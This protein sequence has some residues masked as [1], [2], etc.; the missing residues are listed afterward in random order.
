LKEASTFP[1]LR[2]DIDFKDGFL[3]RLPHVGKH[4]HAA[5]LLSVEA[6]LAATTDDGARA[7]EALIALFQN[8][9]HLADEPLLIPL[10]ATIAIENIGLITLERILS[11]TDLTFETIALLEEQ[12]LTLE[13]RQRL[14]NA[15]QGELL[16]G[17][18]LYQRLSSDAQFRNS[19]LEDIPA[20]FGLRFYQLSGLMAKDRFGYLEMMADYI[21]LAELSPSRILQIGLPTEA[22]SFNPLKGEMLQPVMVPSINRIFKVSIRSTTFLRAA[23]IA[24]AA[25]RFRLATGRFPEDLN[26]LV[27]DYL[28]KLPIDP[29]NPAGNFE[30]IRENSLYFVRSQG[31]FE[32]SGKIIQIEFRLRDSTYTNDSNG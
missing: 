6:V 17:I 22:S 8:A 24:L 13:Q 7:G 31:S 2:N 3:L 27:P 21:D 26:E 19:L 1:F 25:E 4:R 29:F 5:R 15:L 20:V 11:E 10:L 18:E 28:E 23:Q 30:W 9:I 32:S 12:L 14:K 16:N